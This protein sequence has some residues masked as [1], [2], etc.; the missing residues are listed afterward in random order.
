MRNDLAVHTLNILRE[1][2][3]QG[4]LNHPNL[5]HMITQW[6]QK[7]KQ[8]ENFKM[9]EEAKQQYLDVLE[10]QRKFLTELNKDPDLDEEI[11]RWQTYQIDLEE[12]RIKLL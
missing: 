1:K 8:P 11:I 5:M 6:E 12:E 9:N 2:Q 3:Q 4:L 7:I 10:E